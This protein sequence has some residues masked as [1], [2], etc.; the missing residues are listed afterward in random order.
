MHKYRSLDAWKHARQASLLAMQLTDAAYHPRALPLFNQL[1]RASISIE[2]NIVEGYAL[3]ST[4]QFL[5]HLRI[6]LGSAAEAQALLE[7]AITLA[8]L[9]ADNARE[10]GRT[11][12]RT[13]AC[14]SGLIKSMRRRVSKD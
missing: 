6:A 2:V 3:G 8:Y 14:L 13:V 5:R 9:K 7:V 11:I 12:D 4:G 1:R 10:L